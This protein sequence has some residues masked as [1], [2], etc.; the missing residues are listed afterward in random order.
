[1]LRSAPKYG[2]RYSRL[3][4]AVARLRRNLEIV[5]EDLR[6]F[7]RY[8]L[9]KEARRLANVHAEALR[10]LERVKPEAA[11]RLEQADAEVKSA[12]VLYELN[13]RN[14]KRTRESKEKVVTK[15]PR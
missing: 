9:P 3:A 11:S 12:E 6:L 1:M 2:S 4:L 10:Q 8:T 5:Q 7:E 14:L 13:V 15:S